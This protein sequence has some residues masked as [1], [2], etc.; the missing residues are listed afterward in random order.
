V[1]SKTDVQCK[2]KKKK[3][4]VQIQKNLMN[5]ARQSVNTTK[6]P[7]KNKQLEISSLHLS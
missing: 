5:K 4:I 1:N 3:K 2:F 7:K 6:V